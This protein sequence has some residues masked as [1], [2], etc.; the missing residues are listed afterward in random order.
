MSRVKLWF[1]L[2]GPAALL[3]AWLVPDK[4]AW[5][6]A[7]ACRMVFLLYAVVWL[8]FPVVLWG[9]RWSAS[10]WERR[11]ETLCRVRCRSGKVIA[12]IDRNKFSEV[13]GVNTDQGPIH[14][15]FW[16]LCVTRGK[17]GWRIT[18]I[19][20]DFE[21]LN[22]DSVS[23]FFFTLPGFDLNA[24]IACMGV[25]A[26]RTTLLW[27]RKTLDNQQIRN[28]IDLFETQKWRVYIAGI[29]LLFF[30]GLTWGLDS[31]WIIR[32]IG[33]IGV[34]VESMTLVIECSVFAYAADLK[35][36][37]VKPRWFGKTV[38]PKA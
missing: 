20:V 10:R 8:L 23:D 7:A 16:L 18:R 33:V 27:R 9:F 12:E 13:W 34:I 24:Y 15:D 28:Q 38:N 17:P 22:D 14:E 5:P 30:V 1:W 6:S 35:R 25:T 4:L 32:M 29:L 3:L 37:G 21:A 2:S 19:T 11:G 36:I 31:W 26:N